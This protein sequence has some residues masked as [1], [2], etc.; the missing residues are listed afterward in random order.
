[1][2]AEF[3][4]SHPIV[5]WLLV[6]GGGLIVLWA[7]FSRAGGG[8][9]STYA[10]ATGPSDA[11]VN[12]SAAIQAAQIQSQSDAA[13][14]ADAFALQEEQLG[15]AFHIAQ[16]DNARGTHADDL[17]Y[18]LGIA[19][20]N[21]Q[22][23][24]IGIAGEVQKAIATLDAN[25]QI[26]QIHAYRDTS[27]A[28]TNAQVAINQANNKTARKSSSDG[29]LGGIIGGIASIFCDERLKADIQFEYVDP[30]TGLRWYS[31]NY[32][33]SAQKRFGLPSERRIGV[34]AQELL[35]TRYA[36]A[37]TKDRTGYLR[38]NYCAI[39]GVKNG[40]LALA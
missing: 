15:V 24:Q 3:R 18:Q 20:I 29:L 36:Y 16:M 31:F 30:E 40:R 26:E 10:A 39:N 19:N 9:A 35:D 8:G 34:L 1:M 11:Q 14:R 28:V 37:L 32:S 23:Q 17:N 6:I 27:L 2:F 13:A 4:A 22:T 21:A 7:I 38:V 12:A 33:R 25:T 5:F